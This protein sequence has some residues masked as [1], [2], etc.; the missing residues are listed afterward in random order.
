MVMPEPPVLVEVV[1]SG[2]VESRH[3]GSIVALDGDGA[4]TL[5]AGDIADPVFPR[6]A[7]KP[8]QAVAMLH[9][10][11]DLDGELLALAA[12]SH[13]A[14]DFHLVGVRRILAGAGLDE[15]ALRTPPA[16]PLDE[17]ALHRYLRH[18]LEPAR[19]V[20]NCSGKHAAM[21]ATCV[22]NDWPTA[23][24]LDPAHPLQVAIRRTLERGAGERVGV[25]G[26]DG[27]GAP[28]LA[29]SLLA[30]ARTFRAYVVAPEG[31]FERRVVDA[32]R[33]HPVFVGGTR[34]HDARLMAGLPGV[35]AKDG[36]E[37]V[38]AIA[39]ADGRAAAVK[40]TD[41]GRRAA[42]PLVV[43]VLRRFGLRAPVLDELARPTLL[44]GGR[45]VGEIRVVDLERY[46]HHGSRLGG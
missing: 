22:V 36:A 11:L 38:Y 33:A 45:P 17:Q 27:C 21:L 32:M 30:L 39:L 7:S 16:L 1:R 12:G 2:F 44:G 46:A 42:H 40:V 26:V 6:S 20:M 37:G 5:A 35:L 43:A 41:G 10:G 14:E 13:S 18:G 31:S 4:V 15:A 8:I 24:Y 19:I 9:A 34:R 25:T 23:T 29:L 3:R 28:V